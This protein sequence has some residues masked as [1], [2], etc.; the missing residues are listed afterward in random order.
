ML[1]ATLTIT[2]SVV[3]YPEA[4]WAE[5]LHG[6]GAEVSAKPV[7]TLGIDQSLI[8]TLVDFVWPSAVDSVFINLFSNWLWTLWQNSSSRRRS[9]TEIVVEIDKPDGTHS[10]LTINSEL[11]IGSEDVQRMVRHALDH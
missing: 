3:K 9:H 11:K 8:P 4:L 10:V 6:A 7:A 5:A 1:K 2:G